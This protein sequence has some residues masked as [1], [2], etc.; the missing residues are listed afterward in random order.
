MAFKSPAVY[1]PVPIEHTKGP[2]PPGEVWI[3]LICQGNACASGGMTAKILEITAG[4]AEQTIA[5]GDVNCTGDYVRHKFPIAEQ[6]DLSAIRAAVRF[7]CGSQHMDTSLGAILI[8]K[9]E[10][11]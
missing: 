7:T 3:D 10:E 4:G 8:Q 1:F 6:R 5:S 2:P 9:G 11:P